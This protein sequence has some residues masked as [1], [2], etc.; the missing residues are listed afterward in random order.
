MSSV[1]PGHDQGAPR[2]AARRSGFS[3]M[4]MLVVV[5]I[6]GILAAIALPLYQKVTYRARAASI[7]N[8]LYVVRTAAYQYQAEEN[9]WPPDA[10][11]GDVPPDFAP[12]VETV[13][14][15][16]DGYALDWDN[17]DPI[18]G[19]SV[20]VEDP[21]L[22]SAILGTLAESEGTFMRMDDRYTYFIEASLAP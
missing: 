8:D 19:I 21:G 16:G 20:I 18:I 3:L 1:R 2:P 14:F 11:R 9:A 17:W 7:I 5:V 15:A 6:L 4:E 12:Y 10:E 22:E 13:D